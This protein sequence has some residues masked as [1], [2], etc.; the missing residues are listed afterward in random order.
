VKFFR[1]KHKKTGLCYTPVKQTSVKHPSS[2]SRSYI[3]TNLSKRGKVYNSVW[4]EG[5]NAPTHISSH[6][7]PEWKYLGTSFPAAAPEIIKVNFN[8]DFEIEY[9]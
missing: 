4:Y 5:G 7:N 8:E 1:L 2:K 6:L 3:K 9:I